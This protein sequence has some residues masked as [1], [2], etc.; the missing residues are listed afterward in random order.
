M[1]INL[2]KWKVALFDASLLRRAGVESFR[3]TRQADEE[4]G[5][6]SKIADTFTSYYNKAVDTASDYLERIKGLKIEEKAK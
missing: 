4:Q 1:S 3:V 2:R 5:T 6:L